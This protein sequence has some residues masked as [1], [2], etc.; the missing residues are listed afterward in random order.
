VGPALT[1]EPSLRSVFQLTSDLLGS[2]A[3]AVAAQPAQAGLAASVLAGG[4]VPNETAAALLP[5]LAI[6]AP[7]AAA[8]E[9][10]GALR[11]LTEGEQEQV[12]EGGWSTRCPAAKVSCC[13]SKGGSTR[14]QWTVRGP[15]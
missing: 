12:G 1:V 9:Q 7:E 10:A 6:G 14:W 8:L 13:T 3:M 2:A 5:A 4:E 15:G 11:W